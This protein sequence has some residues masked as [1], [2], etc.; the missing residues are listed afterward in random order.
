MDKLSDKQQEIVRR[1]SSERLREK[2]LGLGYDNSTVESLNRQGLMN[3]YAEAFAAKPESGGAEASDD[4]LAPDEQQEQE[5]ASDV[6]R[7]RLYIM[8]MELDERRKMREWDMRKH[9]EQM[10]VRRAE[11]KAQE[12]KN[13]EDNERNNN[14][15]ARLKR[16]GDAL[17]NVLI[18]QSN[19]PIEVVAFFR[20]AEATFREVQVPPEL[21]GILI[22]P[23]LND[24]SKAL[25]ARLEAGRSVMYEEIKTLV[26]NEHKL[27]PAAYQEK[28]GVLRKDEKE[29]YT[30]FSTKLEA[31]MDGYL[32]SRHVSRFS[33]LRDLLICDR[34]KASLD[35]CVLRYILAV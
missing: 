17:K 22:R 8:K 1:M 20:N 33:D 25:V 16:Y 29:T 11:L 21:R 31:L 9:A 4:V 30:M 34:I 5:S 19:D 32:E 23:Y 2:L 35:E 3:T 24:R 10:D 26:L 12:E 14:Q 18:K 6:K 15:A 27:S 7:E 28:F 13:A